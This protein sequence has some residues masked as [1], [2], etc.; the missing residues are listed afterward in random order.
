MKTRYTVY[1]GTN[2]IRSS[3]GIYTL[4]LDAQSG[5]LNLLG[6]TPAYNAG[7]LA[8]AANRPNL[9]AVSEGMTF[10]GR[11]AGG[12]LAYQI[13]EHRLPVLLNSKTTGGQRACCT[14]CAPDGK[15]LYVCNFYGASAAGFSLCGDGSLGDMRFFRREEARK[16]RHDGMHCVYAMQDG[17]VCAVVLGQNCVRFYQPQTGAAL[18]SYE[19]PDG[20]DPRVLV[21]NRACTRVY[22]LMQRPGCIF[23]LENRLPEE[24][25][26][27]LV[28]KVPIVPEGYTGMYASAALRMTP[29]EKYLLASVRGADSLAVFRVEPGTGQLTLAGITKLPGKF[30]RDFNITAD[31]R[32]VVVGLQMSDEAVCYR[33]CAEN[34]TLEACGRIGGIA[35]PAAVVT[36]ME[37]A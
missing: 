3:K 8:L 4:D 21:A 22:L 20:F 26:L 30:P 17:T 25:T 5:A 18:G 16:G 19:I 32:Y 12:V 11:A 6:T 28:Q 33:F 15:T 35:S 9:Y 14:N 10:A 7:Y 2:S 1:V 13:G 31:G 37:E 29:D 24:K 34:G 23:V 36:R 27:R